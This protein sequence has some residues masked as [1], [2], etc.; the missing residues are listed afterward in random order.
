MALCGFQ[1]NL[2]SFHTLL[3]V[4]QI[5]HHLRI[6]GM[7]NTNKQRFPMVSKWCETDFATIHSITNLHL[8]QSPV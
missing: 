2:E 5:L 3:W 1:V 7:V 8:L 4:N 6:P